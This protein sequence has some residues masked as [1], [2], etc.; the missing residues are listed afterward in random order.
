MYEFHFCFSVFWFLLCCK[1][2]IWKVIKPQK[3]CK[4]FIGQRYLRATKPLNQ[5]FNKMYWGKKIGKWLHTL[6][7]R[8]A[9]NKVVI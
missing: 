3:N 9:E 7:G 2:G 5:K 1:F 8:E 6:C 4:V